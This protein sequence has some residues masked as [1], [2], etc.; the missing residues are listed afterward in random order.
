[1]GRLS[2]DYKLD[3]YM[4]NETGAVF[5]LNELEDLYNSEDH[6]DYMDF[7]GYINSIKFMNDFTKVY[8][9]SIDAMEDHVGDWFSYDDAFDALNKIIKALGL[10]DWEL[11]DH[12]WFLINLKYQKKN[13][14]RIMY[15]LIEN[16]EDYC[17]CE[18]KINFDE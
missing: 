11:T 5:T 3:R 9:K 10:Q 2:K 16:V 4:F 13:V 6:N 15:D 18:K 12:E 14:T 8:P 17:T 7:N 1:M